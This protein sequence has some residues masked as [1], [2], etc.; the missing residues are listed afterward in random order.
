M[1]N[2]KP[3]HPHRTCMNE[4]DNISYKFSSRRITFIATQTIVWIQ[5]IPSAEFSSIPF[6]F[7]G[8]RNYYLLFDEANCNYIDY[9]S[10]SETHRKQFPNN[11]GCS[12]A[13]YKKIKTRK[14]KCNV[15]ERPWSE[16][17]PQNYKPL[18][19]PVTLRLY[20]RKFITAFLDTIDNPTNQGLLTTHLFRPGP[21]RPHPTVWPYKYFIGWKGLGKTYWTLSTII[22]ILC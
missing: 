17:K 16:E 8:Q 21:W 10:V 2:R 14:T 15:R 12:L 20:D 3:L 1:G 19:L 13:T 22:L 9:P 18:T 5:W 6:M 4:L 7:T 11:L